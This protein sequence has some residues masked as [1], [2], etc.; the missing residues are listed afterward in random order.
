MPGEKAS[1]PAP[2]VSKRSLERIVDLHQR[3]TQETRALGAHHSR[4]LGAL[5]ACDAHTQRAMIIEYRD[6]L[7]SLH[8][9]IAAL[10]NLIDRYDPDN[11]S[12]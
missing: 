5:L 7:H 6:R 2:R 12:E 9:L 10:S 3:L 11:G 8:K 1:L 4:L